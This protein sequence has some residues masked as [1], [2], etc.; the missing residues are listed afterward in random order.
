M[1]IPRRRISQIF[2]YSFTKTHIIIRISKMM[3]PKLLPLAILM[4][5]IWSGYSK[6]IS[7]TVNLHSL[8]IIPQTYFLTKFDI[9]KGSGNIT[10]D[11]KYSA[12][13][14]GK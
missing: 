2:V 14:L 6:I 5:L 1:F 12:A 13:E 11:F 9:G 10:I 7:K 8:A 3:I 4:I